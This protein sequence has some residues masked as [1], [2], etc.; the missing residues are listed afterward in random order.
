MAKDYYLVK[1]SFYMKTL[2]TG[3]LVIIAIVSMAGMVMAD[4]PDLV[5]NWTGPYSEYNGDTGFNEQETG[6]FFLNITEQKDRIIIGHTRFA[7]TGT[8][9]T[10]EIAGIISADG[11]QLSITE[12]NNGY[13]TGRIIGPDEIELTYLDDK[14][15][16][17]VA[18]DQFFRIP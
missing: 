1:R 10:R 15:P 17:S 7:D 12:E 13:S 3:F 2:V 4:I 8:D 14:E 6:F 18:I 9:V 16:I 11:T 5:G